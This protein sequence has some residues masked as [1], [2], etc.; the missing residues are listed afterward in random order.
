M[1][2]MARKILNATDEQHEIVVGEKMLVK[3]W[4]DHWIWRQSRSAA[5][6]NLITADI[7]I[8]FVGD[9]HPWAMVT[10]E[11]YPM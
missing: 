1:W 6:K 9:E 11:Q 4:N 3:K 8:L 5:G 7:P 2:W 10:E